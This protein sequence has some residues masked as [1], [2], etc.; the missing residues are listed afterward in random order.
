MKDR[1]NDKCIGRRFIENLV[2]K[3][4]HECTANLIHGDR[5]EMWM[6]LDGEDTR[7][8]APKKVLAESG[9]TAFI[10]VV[11]PSNIIAS[12]LGE[13]DVLNHAAHVPAA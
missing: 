6:P 9:P 13:N 10:P 4:T 5:K 12:F 11:G 2:R 7:L 1:V 3:A 8:D